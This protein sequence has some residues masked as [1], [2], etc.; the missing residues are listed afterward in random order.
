MSPPRYTPIS[1]NLKPGRITKRTCLALTTLD[2]RALVEL[3]QLTE[4]EN[5][6]TLIRQAVRHYAKFLSKLPPERIAREMAEANRGTYAH[7]C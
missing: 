6:T 4:T 7:V 1:N 2:E 3:L 5:R